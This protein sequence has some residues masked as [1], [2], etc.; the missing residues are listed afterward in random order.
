MQ[1]DSDEYGGMKSGPSAAGRKAA[2]DDVSLEKLLEQ[3][4][5]WVRF[6]LRRM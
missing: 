5:L 2:D 6:C 1:R 4:L 3:E